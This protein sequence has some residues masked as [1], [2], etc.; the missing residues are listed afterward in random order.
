MTA[1]VKALA[2]LLGAVGTW[3]VTASDGGIGAGEWFG[4]VVALGTALSV[5]AFPNVPAVTVYDEDDALAHL[6]ET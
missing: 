6:E 5:Y 1:Y 2:A 3:G 4:L